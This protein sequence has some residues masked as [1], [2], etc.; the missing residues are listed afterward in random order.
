MAGLSQVPTLGSFIT[1][2]CTG[3]GDGSLMSI[4]PHRSGLHLLLL[5]SGQRIQ[6]CNYTT[7][8]RWNAAALIEAQTALKPQQDGSTQSPESWLILAMPSLSRESIRVSYR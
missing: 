2:A 3:R 6:P 1:S 5:P 4:R 7:L 8:I